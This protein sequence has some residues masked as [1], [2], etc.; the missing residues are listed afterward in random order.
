MSLSAI[1]VSTAVRLRRSQ[2][3][4]DDEEH[5]R[6]ISHAHGA[7]QIAVAVFNVDMDHFGPKL[8][9]L[10]PAVKKIVKKRL[11]KTPPAGLNRRP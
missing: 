6:T 2:A 5:R 10:A 4:Y 8:L 11:G 9:A 1:P 3:P 7:G